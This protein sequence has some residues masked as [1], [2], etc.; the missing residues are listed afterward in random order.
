METLVLFWGSLFDTLIGSNIFVFGEPF[1]LAAGAALYS[2]KVIGVIAVMLGGW[3]GD[4]GS[5]WI[6]RRWGKPLRRFLFRRY[7]RTRRP[8]AR[9]HHLL[10]RRTRFILIF[11][12]VMGPVAWVVPFLAGAQGV[13]WSTFTLYGAI[14]L[15]LGIGQFVLWGYLGAAGL[16]QLGW[17]QPLALFFD[18]HANL[19]IS[20][21]IVL[22]LW[23]LI[24]RSAMAFRKTLCAAVLLLAL[25]AVNY[26]HFFIEN[27][28]GKPIPTAEG[29]STTLE[30]VEWTTYPGEA[31]VYP[32]Q[33]INVVLIGSSPETL[34]SALG[35]IKN[36]TFS[37]DDFDL[38][39]YVTMLRVKQPPVSDLFWQGEAQWQAWQLPGSLVA[40][41]HIRWWYAGVSEKSGLPVWL[42]ALSYD[43]GLKTAHYRGIITLLHRI[44]KDVDSER[45]R[46]ATAI[47]NALP[48]W[49][50]VTLPAQQAHEANDYYTDGNVLVVGK[51]TVVGSTTPNWLTQ[52]F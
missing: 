34:M 26:V 8:I 23:V 1:L 36:Y 16:S 48:S 4:Q 52:L 50:A 6:G 29:R 35:W 20:L 3:C 19:L 44:A 13:R 31:S 17:W 21:L 25:G 10:Q 24:W 47:Q 42:G 18:E 32:A 14:G 41:S 45:E 43:D 33:P 5:Y 27:E 11:A 7:Q 15:C 22:V 49:S 39:E 51:P 9:A 2:G 37:R 28:Q 40:R 38:D 30:Q 12:R 46:M